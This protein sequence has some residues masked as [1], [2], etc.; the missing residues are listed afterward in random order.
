MKENFE[1]FE[2]FG[3]SKS[4]ARSLSLDLTTEEALSD[5]TRE[6]I[7]LIRKYNGNLADIDDE[8]YLL[9]S[10]LALLPR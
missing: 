2:S 9:L 5:N 10:F 7:E 4:V 1:V 8:Y 6:N 3:F